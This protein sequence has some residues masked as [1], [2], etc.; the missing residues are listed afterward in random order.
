M[1]AELQL[2]L[3]SIIDAVDRTF[4]STP[5]FKILHGPRL[6]GGNSHAGAESFLTNVGL[7]RFNAGIICVALQHGINIHQLSGL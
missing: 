2:V 4:R 3:E 1:T 6:L 5:E 7:D